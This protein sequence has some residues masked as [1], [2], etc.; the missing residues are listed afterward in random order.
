MTA[1]PDNPPAEFSW[2]AHPAGERLGAAVTGSLIILATAAA[3]L[4][5][6]RSYAWSAAAVVV[7]VLSLNRFYFRS[8]FRIDPEGISARYPLRSQRCRWADV[9]R[10]MVDEHGGYLSTRSRRS[11]LDAYRGLHVLFGRRRPEVIERIRAHLPRK[12][13]P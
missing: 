11:W 8:R 4:L 13:R 9:R 1:A 7:L 6:F 3:I 12:D 10:F 2:Q 5:S